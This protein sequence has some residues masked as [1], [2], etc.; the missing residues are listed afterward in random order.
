MIKLLNSSTGTPTASA[1]RISTSSR[2]ASGAISGAISGTAS[3]VIFFPAISPSRILLAVATISS[4]VSAPPIVSI[5]WSNFC[6]DSAMASG[7][8][9][10]TSV[11]AAVVTPTAPPNTPP[12]TAPAAARSRASLRSIFTLV[13]K[14]SPTYS[15]IPSCIASVVASF[16]RAL[17]P[18]LVIRAADSFTPAFIISLPIS[19]FTWDVIPF[20]PMRSNNAEA[21]ANGA[22]SKISTISAFS[23]PLFLARCSP[24]S[25][26]LAKI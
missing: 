8:L 12:A 25:P 6:R 5:V 26:D 15:I 22:A 20:A 17:P 4:T 24:I 19:S 3:G 21:A 16:D 18:A 14:R 13:P 2:A 9:T 1:A 10:V 11:T 7:G 23:F